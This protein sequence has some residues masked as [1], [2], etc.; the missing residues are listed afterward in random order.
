MLLGSV[1][2]AMMC[3]AGI[4]WTCWLLP[5]LLAAP[6]LYFGILLFSPVR[7]ARLTSFM[8][9]EKYKDTIGYQLW[10]SQLAL[11]S[12]EWVGVGFA[13]SRLKLKYLPE[14][15]TDFILSIVGEELGFVMVLLVII[16]YLILMF[17]GIRISQK[18]RNLQGMFT[19]YGMIIFIIIQAVINLGVVCGAF[20]TKG[21]PAPMISYGGSNLIACMIA[22][23][24]VFSVALDSA[25]PD[26]HL[27]IQQEL[28][29]IQ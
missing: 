10:N 1:F 15:H 4:H 17:T 8:D 3:V 28:R 11:G 6:V 29:N 9:P 7:L 13:E 20:P 19:A 26:Y 16:A 24:C 23:G 12:G 21:M 27:D 22:V 2:L 18:S 5:P 14:A 25:Y